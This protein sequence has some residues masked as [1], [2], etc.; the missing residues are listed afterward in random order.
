[1]TTQMTDAEVTEEVGL[2]EREPLW[3]LW[4]LLPV[5]HRNRHT[6]GH[7][8]DEGLGV[9][10][11]GAGPRVYLKSLFEFKTGKLEPQIEG[12]RVLEFE[13]LADLV[14]AG[15]MGD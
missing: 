7:P 4:P 12:V 9:M 3:P 10:I 6:K 13:T 5:K 1:M 14:R 8:K 11:A 2:I 15:W